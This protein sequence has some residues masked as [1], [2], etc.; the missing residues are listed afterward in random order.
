V[1]DKRNYESRKIVTAKIVPEQERKKGFQN[2]ELYGFS[3]ASFPNGEKESSLNFAKWRQ[4]KKQR[5][6]I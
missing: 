3:L 6:E 1:K 5:I 4:N 2:E